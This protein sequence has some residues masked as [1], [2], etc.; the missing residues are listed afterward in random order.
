MTTMWSPGPGTTGVSALKE[1]KEFPFLGKDLV[2]EGTF[3]EDC[4]V[5]WQ[6]MCK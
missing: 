6:K 3:R 5:I 2:L 1:G 4:N